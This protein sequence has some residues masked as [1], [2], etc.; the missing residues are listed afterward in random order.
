VERHKLK[1]VDT[2]PLE[3]QSFVLVAKVIAWYL[4]YWQSCC[5]CLQPS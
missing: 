5:V 1:E 4:Q 3:P 2:L